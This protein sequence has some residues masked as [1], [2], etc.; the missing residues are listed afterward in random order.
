M[1]PALAL[2]AMIAASAGA[3]DV[4]RAEAPNAAARACALGVA[5]LRPRVVGRARE[6]R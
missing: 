4:V 3:Q 1:I 2:A 6:L 5:G